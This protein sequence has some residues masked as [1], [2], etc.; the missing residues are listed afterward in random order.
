MNPKKL[1]FQAYI[2]AMYFLYYLTLRRSALRGALFRVGQHHLLAPTLVPLYVHRG[3][4][5]ITLRI[6][7]LQLLRPFP[8]HLLCPLLIHGLHLRRL[9]GPSLGVQLA[10]HPL[11]QVDG[12][13]LA[14]KTSFAQLFA[15]MLYKGVYLFLYLFTFVLTDLV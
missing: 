15:L 8:E 1:C 4:S 5:H 12:V 7:Q 6:D 3:A 10:L 9:T 13:A 11:L 2:T 14:V